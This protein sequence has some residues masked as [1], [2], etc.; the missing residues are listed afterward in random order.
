MPS[1][2]FV[3]YETY[4]ISE[5]SDIVNEAMRVPGF[6]NHVKKPQPPTLLYGMNPFDML[7]DLQTKVA[8]K[9]KTHFQT[10][11]AGERVEVTRRLPPNAQVLFSGVVSVPR[12]WD[13]ENADMADAC[14]RDVVKE[15]KRLYGKNLRG[16]LT[17]NDEANRHIHFYVYDDSLA[18]EKVCTATAAEVA[19]DRSKKTET[20]AERY[21]ARSKALIQYQDTW[22]TN[23]FSEY[24]F[25]RLGPKRKRESRSV[26][27]ADRMQREAAA[28]QNFDTKKR[29]A[30]VNKAVAGISGVMML[31]EIRHRAL[32]DTMS[33]DAKSR[34]QVELVRAAVAAGHEQTLASF[35]L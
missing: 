34:H 2:Q 13:D 7:S 29:Q 30:V 12:D 6:C 26:A 3:T 1:Y 19:V 11:K 18:L 32:H 10:N 16:V 31:Q 24:G 23:V 14:F 17:H 28:R 4:N 27:L 33:I 5:S 35:G 9:T 22:F 25:S 8:A 21:K 15:L 20:G